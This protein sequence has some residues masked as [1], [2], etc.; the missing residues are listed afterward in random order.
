MRPCVTS[1][2]MLTVPENNSGQQPITHLIAERITHGYDN[3][4]ISRPRRL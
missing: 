4:E 3:A 2:K 1:A